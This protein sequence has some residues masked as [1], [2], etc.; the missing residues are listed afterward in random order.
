MPPAAVTPDRQVSV[1]EVPNLGLLDGRFSPNIITTTL[2]KVFNWA[3]RSEIL[4]E[5]QAEQEQDGGLP[6]GVLE[7]FPTGSTRRHQ[8][9]HHHRA[10]GGLC[11]KKGKQRRRSSGLTL[12]R[13]LL[14]FIKD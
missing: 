1:D 8:Q 14:Y 2:D 13:P 6:D 4:P 7:E 9:Q 10:D 11:Q 3:R 5:R 12:N